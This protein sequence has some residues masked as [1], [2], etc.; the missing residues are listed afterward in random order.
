MRRMMIRYTV[1]PSEAAT[2]EKLVRAVY[3]ELDQVQPGG[4][5]YATFKLDDGLTF[6]HLVQMDGDGPGP[7]Q[8]IAAFG[9]FTAGV[10][11]RC[12]V[13]PQTSTLHEVG[14]YRLFT[15]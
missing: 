14:S 13:L 10:E 1:K 3:A 9:E 8:Q 2:N 7:L 6:V 5:G 12:E 4:L 15:P 11:A